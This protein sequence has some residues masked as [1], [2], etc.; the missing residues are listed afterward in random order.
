MERF[1]EVL[2]RHSACQNKYRVEII[3]GRP[4]TQ[5]IKP[6][7][8]HFEGICRDTKLKRKDYIGLIFAVIEVNPT[9]PDRW[10]TTANQSYGRR[11]RTEKKIINNLI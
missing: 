1:S 6:L 9:E 2:E 4:H 10:R 8:H 7:G 5:T 3:P 11:P